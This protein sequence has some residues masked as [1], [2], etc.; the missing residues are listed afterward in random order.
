MS[1]HDEGSLV[2]E[3]K[4]SWAEIVER[5]EEEAVKPVKPIPKQRR[6]KPR[7]GLNESQSFTTYPSFTEDL[8]PVFLKGLF[9]VIQTN[10]QALFFIANQLQNK[11]M[12]GPA[13]IFPGQFTARSFNR[14]RIMMPRETI[15]VIGDKILTA[16]ELSYYQ[17]FCF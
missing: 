3:K 11:C 13:I 9:K 16:V 7:P 14:M 10:Q 6:R 8:V 1:S 12:P 4:L 2:G 15:L 17:S 5:A